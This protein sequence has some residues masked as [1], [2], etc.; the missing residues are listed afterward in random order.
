MSGSDQEPVYPL[1]LRPLALTKVWGGRRLERVLGK[2]LPGRGPIGEVWVVWDRLPIA[3]GPRRGQTLGNLRASDG[4]AL[5]GSAA[6]DASDVFPL[7]VKF[8]D[9]QEDLSVQVHPDDAYARQREGQPYGK[10]EMWYVLD[11][12]PGATVVHGT[13]RDVSP[14]ELLAALRAGRVGDVLELVEVRAGDV[15]LNR[16]GTIHALGRG[17]VVYELQQACDLTY[18]LYD[19]NRGVATG[20]PREL[21]L[22][23]ALDVA[24]LRPLAVHQI[25][26][27][28]V[29]AG[30]HTR[31]YLCAC[32]SFAAELVTVSTAAT[33]ERPGGRCRI[34]TVLDGTATLRWGRPSRRLVLA[35]GQ[36]AL[37]P[38]AVPAISIV[39]AGP[40]LRLIEA[41]V[42]DLARDVVAPLRVRGVAPERIA[43]LGGD[44]RGSDLLPFLGG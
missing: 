24:D 16:P 40:P 12:A 41:Y 33:L 30:D 2:R 23:Q 25:E 37:V 42:P 6:R 15:L 18:R 1:R 39:A 11:A 9:A 19:W 8:L 31:A 5:L 7:L 20:Q 27:I 35:S 38:A 26:P 36:T 29:E 17:I 34:L 3:N 22:A 10:C 13:R 14:E 28:A 44:P 32:R 21:H 4:E 43:R